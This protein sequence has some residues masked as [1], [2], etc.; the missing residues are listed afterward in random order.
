TTT[1]KEG[2]ELA[3]YLV[4]CEICDKSLRKYSLKCHMRSHQ[5]PSTYLVKCKICGKNL[6]W[7]HSLRTHMITHGE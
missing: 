2:D 4:K 7:K 1:H 6:K 3:K 5:D